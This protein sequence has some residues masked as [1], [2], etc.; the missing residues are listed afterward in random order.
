MIKRSMSAKGNSNSAS[1]HRATAHKSR[2]AF[3]VAVFLLLLSFLLFLCQLINL[4]VFKAAASG[5]DSLPVSMRATSQADYSRDLHALTIPPISENLLRQI[6]T[7]IPATGSPQDRM[8][9]L[10]V[11]LSSP[12]PTMTPDHRFTVTFTPTRTI[13]PF[14]SRTPTSTPTLLKTQAPTSVLI[15]R[16][17]LH[18][19]EHSLQYEHPPPRKQPLVRELSS[20]PLHGRS[21]RQYGGNPDRYST[22]TPT[23]TIAHQYPPYSDNSDRYPHINRYAQLRADIERHVH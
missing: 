16:N 20:R 19:Q 21:H 3:N 13:V 17:L 12:V 2:R 5:S 15:E 14:P 9:T 18:Q 4:G 10:Q 22:P 7:D 6:I 11:V 23:A 1:T 8:A